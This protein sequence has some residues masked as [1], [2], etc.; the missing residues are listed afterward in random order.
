MDFLQNKQK[1][2]LL[3]AEELKNNPK[4]KQEME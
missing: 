4:E 3:K 2:K 1:N